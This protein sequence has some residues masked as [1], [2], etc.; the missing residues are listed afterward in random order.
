MQFEC[1]CTC[2]VKTR[3]DPDA[4]THGTAARRPKSS[5]PSTPRPLHPPR[6]EGSRPPRTLRRG[7]PRGRGPPRP[8]DPLDPSACF[9]AIPLHVAHEHDTRPVT[10][11]KNIA[12]RQKRPLFAAL[13]SS[14]SAQN[15]NRGHPS[16]WCAA[17]HRVRP[18]SHTHPHSPP[19]RAAAKMSRDRHIVPDQP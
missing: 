12:R 11:E 5:H 17:S 4:S 6:V 19:A 2:Y 1:V 18:S 16:R 8:L 14:R 3:W 10:R 9:P 13:S 15:H 7:P